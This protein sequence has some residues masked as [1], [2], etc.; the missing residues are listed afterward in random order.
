ML[1][2]I[3]PG[4]GGC[5]IQTQWY[6]HVK[7]ELEKRGIQVI[8]ENMPDADLARK[9]YWLPFIEQKTKG[10]SNVILIGHSSGA[11]AILRYLETHRVL[12]A[13]LVAAC[14]TDLGNEHEK[15]SHYFD[16]PW[17]WEKIHKNAQWIIQF[18]SK[19]DPYIP[20]EEARFI[21]EKL[22][23]DYHEYADQG[24]FSQDTA[25]KTT[26]P[27]LIEAVQRKIG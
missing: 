22:Q 26:F 24:H 10:Q 15:A 7:D 1:A 8:A 18:A 4:N 20:I 14:H 6:P 21:H 19:N 23:T 5:G 11:V 12:G 27:E 3:L 13:V 25:G 16:E 17:Q 9:E 2:L